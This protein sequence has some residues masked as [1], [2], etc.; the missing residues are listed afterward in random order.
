[1]VEQRPPDAAFG[2]DPE[3]A[4]VLHGDASRGGERRPQ[5][6]PLRTQVSPILDLDQFVPAIAPGD[7]EVGCVRRDWPSASK[8]MAIGCDLTVAPAS[9]NCTSITKSRSSALSCS[10]ASPSR[11]WKPVTCDRRLSGMRLIS[12]P[13]SRSFKAT[14]H[15]DV[16]VSRRFKDQIYDSRE[17]GPCARVQKDSAFS[18]DQ[19]PLQGKATPRLGAKWPGKTPPDS[20]SQTPPRSRGHR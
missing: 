11:G 19:T 18:A 14:I 8:R 10:I 16:G 15:P 1:M 6:L 9:A 7:V 13:D 5:P 4:S 2:D 12:F 17:T 3:P 20:V